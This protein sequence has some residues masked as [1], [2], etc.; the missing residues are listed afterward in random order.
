MISGEIIGVGYVFLPSTDCC[1][2]LHKCWFVALAHDVL[3]PWNTFSLLHMWNVGSL[4]MM[5]VRHHLLQICHLFTLGYTS[6]LYI[7]RAPHT[8]LWLWPLFYH[9]DLFMALCPQSVVPPPPMAL[10]QRGSLPL[11][12]L[13]QCPVY[14]R[15]ITNVC[16][17]PWTNVNHHYIGLNVNW[18]PKSISCPWTCGTVI[19]IYT[20][21]DGHVF[22]VFWQ[23]SVLL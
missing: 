13:R 9:C 10:S 12:Q 20:I 14:R 23:C 4:L 5:H 8:F 21:P 11:P 2:S 1:T 15:N 7:L 3:S 18:T 22:A 17:L 6:P 16:C 19:L